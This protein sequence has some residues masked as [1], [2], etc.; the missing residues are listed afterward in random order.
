MLERSVSGVDNAFH[1][2]MDLR[3]RT[4]RRDLR[5]SRYG[6]RPARLDVRAKTSTEFIQAETSMGMEVKPRIKFE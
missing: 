1:R 6:R 3:I 4:F 2:K 5:S